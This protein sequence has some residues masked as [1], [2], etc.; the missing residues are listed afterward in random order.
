MTVS[1]REMKLF[2]ATYEERSFTRAALRENATQP[3]V[4]QHIRKLEER[5]NVTLFH[6]LPEGVDPT[7]AADRFYLEAVEVLRAHVRAIRSVEQF[8]KGTHE[9]ISV[10]L[11]PSITRCALA[12]ALERFVVDFPNARLRIVEAYSGFLTQQVQAGVLDFAVVPPSPDTSKL[13]STMLLRTPEILASSR[14][15]GSHKS[16]ESLRLSECGPLKMVVPARGNVRRDTL[17]N[18]FRANDVQIER[19]IELDAVLGALTLIAQTEWVQVVPAFV[20]DIEKDAQIYNLNPIR[21]P[22]I[23]LD[24]I[25]IEQVATPLSPA[26]E[27]FF[28]MLAEALRELN[29]PWQ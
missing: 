23:W 10:G 22:A 27:A 15:H 28:G 8:S 17:E 21:D 14:S 24:L 5:L 26:A 12:P 3:G 9:Q 29:R 7:P 1:L 2:V 6:R 20:F 18:Y 4:S 11:M 13:R 19:L 16:M 25:L